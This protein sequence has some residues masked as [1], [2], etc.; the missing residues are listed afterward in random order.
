MVV[1]KREGELGRQVVLVCGEGID[2]PSHP[3][4]TLAYRQV[5]ALHPGRIDRVADRRSLFCRLNENRGIM[6]PKALAFLMWR[7]V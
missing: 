4:C 1:R 6:N 7:L 2:L 3:P 5:V